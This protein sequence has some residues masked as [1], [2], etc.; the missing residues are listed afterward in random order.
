[1]ST[2]YPLDPFTDFATKVEYTHGFDDPTLKDMDS[3]PWGRNAEGW[4]RQESRPP[5]GNYLGMGEDNP[6][7]T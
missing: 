4:E 5:A 3:I 6:Y 1:M 2:E 7:A